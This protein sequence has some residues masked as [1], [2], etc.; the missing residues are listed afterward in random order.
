MIHFVGIHRRYKWYM[1][2][3]REEPLRTLGY[4]TE[5]IGTD[6]EKKGWMKCVDEFHVALNVYKNPAKSQMVYIRCL[7][8][9]PSREFYSQDKRDLE[10]YKAYTRMITYHEMLVKKYNYDPDWLLESTKCRK[11]KRRSKCCIS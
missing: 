2:L 11:C 5:W 10:L 3:V 4:R 1:S 6:K 7:G 9:D 8:Q